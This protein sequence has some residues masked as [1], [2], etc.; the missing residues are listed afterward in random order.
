MSHSTPTRQLFGTDGVRG[1]AN[2]HPMTAEVALKL[3]RAAAHLFRQTP[4]RHKIVI[5][6][7]TRLSGYMLESAIA[8][9]ITS[10]GVDVVLLGPLPT[11]G[12]AY[13]TR[14]L[15]ADAGVV[16]TASHNEY[17][18]NGIKFFRGDGYK[19][20]DAVETEIERLVFSGEI[21]NIRP[22]AQE[23]G[24]AFRSEDALGR[25]IESAKRAFPASADLEGLCVAVDCANGATYKSTPAILRELGANVKAHHISPDGMNINANCGSTHPEEIQRIVRET[26]A[27]VGLTHDGDGDR[28]I[29]CDE[30]GEIVDGDEVLAIIAAD[31]LAKG[32][33]A[34]NTL[35]A[36]VM[37]NMGLDEFIES[38]GGRVIRTQVGDRYV[39]EE[40]LRGGF[41]LGGEQSGHMILRDFSTTGDGIVSALQVLAVMAQTGRRLSELRAQMRRYPQK[42]INVKVRER[43]PFEAM[44]AVQTALAAAEKELQGRGRVF[45][46]YSGTEPKVRLLL[47]D[48]EGDCLDRLA[49]QILEP[50]RKEIGI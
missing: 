7:D 34:G 45:L 17:A 40:M 4:R 38:K 36:T 6:K 46:R 18:D 16:I 32:Q 44:P 48:R 14:A 30:R 47:E 37:S 35:V 26:G 39:L 1:V 50:L 10:L 22:T 2:V 41:N 9:G 49:T 31:Y 29:L 43:R 23:I 33:L 21:D 19:L 11:P 25:Y 24:K 5:A 42:L 27:Q 3:G 15:R 12:A 8:S 20:D 13:I 28:V